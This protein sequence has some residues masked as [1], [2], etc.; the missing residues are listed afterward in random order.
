MGLVSE[1]KG[2]CHLSAVRSTAS[3]QTQDFS[4]SYG[5]DRSSFSVTLWSLSSSLPVATISSSMHHQP[6]QR[7]TSQW[8]TPQKVPRKEARSKQLHSRADSQEGKCPHAHSPTADIC[9]TYI[10]GAGCTQCNPVAALTF[11]ITHRT[12]SRSGCR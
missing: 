11:T 4:V 7:Q 8:V 12:I 2:H 3:G 1:G 6:R 9:P 5:H 10:T